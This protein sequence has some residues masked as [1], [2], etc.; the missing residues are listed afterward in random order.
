M[1][2]TEKHKLAIAFRVYPL[3]SKIPAIYPND[4]FKLTQ[5][6][7]RSLVNSL[8]NIH[9]KIWVIFDGCPIEYVKLFDSELKDLEKEYIFFEKAGNPKTFEKQVDILLNQDFSEYIYFAEDDYFYLENN[10]REALDFYK[11]FNPDF[12]TTY[13][14]P[15]NNTL[16]IAKIKRNNS[17]IIQFNNYTW[18]IQASTTMTFMTTKSK[19]LETKEV[20][21]TYARKNFDNAMWFSLTNYNLT[22]IFVFLYYLF[23]N[24]SIAYIFGKAYYFVPYQLFFGKKYK[25]WV[26]TDSLCTHLEA[27][28]LGKEVNWD[29]E[30]QKIKDEL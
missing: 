1:N 10:F 21:L 8:R 29:I 28:T 3:I 14:H 22:N 18:Q 6:G 2:L 19:L 30:F 15:D 24:K 20:F 23:T 5:I 9:A 26:I 12:L 17:E 25:L 11:M 4:K 27:S 7:L 16:K 13:N